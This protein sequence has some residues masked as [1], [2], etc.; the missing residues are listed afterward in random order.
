MSERHWNSP[1]L[2]LMKNVND[3]AER[4]KKLCLKTEEK[5]LKF[6]YS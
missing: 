2:L 4:S 3:R 1:E 6:A 5:M